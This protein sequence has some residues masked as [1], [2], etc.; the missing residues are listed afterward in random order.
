MINRIV[1]AALT[2]SL[3]SATGPT[4]P[5]FAAE[6]VI[7]LP[8]ELPC[9]GTQGKSRARCITDALKTWKEMEKDYDDEEDDVIAAWKAEHAQMGV[10]SDYQ[11][12]LHTFL[13]DVRAQRKEFRAQLNAF[14]KAFFAEQKIQREKGSVPAAESLTSK[15][16]F[17][18]AKA[19]CGEED[20]DGLYRTCIRHILRL[21]RSSITNRSRTSPRLQR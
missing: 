6:D 11:R 14:R 2:L 18:A 17:D 20:D 3:L 10:G 5:A 4:A 7:A 21:K 9:E 1:S 16:D 15:D 13:N 8:S 12:A 19:K